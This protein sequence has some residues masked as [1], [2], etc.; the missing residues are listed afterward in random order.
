MR[1][2][3]SAPE[4]HVPERRRR[5]GRLRRDVYLTTAAAPAPFAM[6]RAS[7]NEERM[8]RVLRL[9]LEHKASS[10]RNSSTSGARKR[11]SR[12]QSARQQQRAAT[13]GVRASAAPTRTSFARSD[14]ACF[15]AS[16]FFFWRRFTIPRRLPRGG[17]VRKLFRAQ[18][19]GHS[20]RRRRQQQPRAGT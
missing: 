1:F 13:T 2:S 3:S 6:A 10:A 19:A 5:G 20:S 15:L 4:R 7:S 11:S 17:E 8:A 9:A 14:V 12:A 18:R 16:L